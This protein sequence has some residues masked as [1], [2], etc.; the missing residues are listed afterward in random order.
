M[1][2]TGT[3]AR[4][5]ASWSARRQTPIWTS[6][7]AA[8]K[9]GAARFG[10]LYRVWQ[11][12]GVDVLRSVQMPTLREQ[13]QR[14]RGARRIRRTSAPVLATRPARRHVQRGRERPPRGGQPSHRVGCPRPFPIS[15]TF[16]PWPTSLRDAH[17]ACLPTNPGKQLA[18]SIAAIGR[19]TVPPVRT[20][21]RRSIDEQAVV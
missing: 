6:T 21:R 18:S 9:F 3:F 20:P 17:C 2:S 19:R 11:Q 1:S 14:G 5:E 4:V 7:T 16:I 10:A 15:R 8:R 12:R 13:L